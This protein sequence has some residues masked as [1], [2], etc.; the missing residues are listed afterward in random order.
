MSRPLGYNDAIARSKRNQKVDSEEL[1][2]LL[3]PREKQLAPNAPS[4]SPTATS[5]P[6][7]MSRVLTLP[8]NAP[9]D[10]EQLGDVEQVLLSEQRLAN[11]LAKA[12]ADDGGQVL[13]AGTTTLHRCAIRDNLERCA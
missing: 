13:P 7:P 5:A 1:L 12:A 4:Q 3:R 6:L 2:A 10:S 8:A 9:L 11:K